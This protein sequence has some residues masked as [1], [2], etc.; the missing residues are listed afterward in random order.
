MEVFAGQQL[1]IWQRKGPGKRASESVHMEEVTPDTPL[2]A[3]GLKGL[4]TLL[5]GPSSRRKAMKTYTSPEG[6]RCLP[7]IAGALPPAER[8]WRL[9]LPRFS[10]DRIDGTGALPPAERQWRGGGG[11]K[12]D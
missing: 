4:P 1:R 6:C 5:W 8:Q 2:A 7:P 12:I 11:T 10:R 3:L 9:F